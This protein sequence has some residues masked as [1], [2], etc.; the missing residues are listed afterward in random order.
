MSQS[1]RDYFISRKLAIKKSTIPNA[2]YGV[3]AIEKIYNM[4]IIEFSPVQLCHRDMLY[5]YGDTWMA[6]YAFT[7]T[8][9]HAAIAF[10][11]A[12]MDNHNFENNVSYH[13]VEEPRGIE[14]IALRDIDPGEELFDLY[15]VP[16]NVQNLWF[17][18]EY[19]AEDGEENTRKPNPVMS[20]APDARITER[21]KYKKNRSGNIKSCSSPG[22]S[23]FYKMSNNVDTEIK[24]D[25]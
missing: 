8:K 7:W 5:E 23:R 2:G 12:G 25:D 3:F 14:F 9:D 10:G 11:W 18:P 20:V 1:D 24:E 19:A 22:F 15:C 16:S 21:H 6:D 17:V 13:M 4:E